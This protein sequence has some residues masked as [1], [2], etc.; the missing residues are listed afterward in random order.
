MPVDEAD[1]HALTNLGLISGLTTTILASGLALAFGEPVAE[2]FGWVQGAKWLWIIPLMALSV[3]TYQVLNALA[4]RQQ[5]FG[6]I[7]RRSL[8]QSLTGAAAQIVGGIMHSGFWG[9][10]LGQLVGNV[11][12]TLSLLW[13]S[14]LRTSDARAARR[15]PRLMA[16][17]K[18]YRKFPLA[19]APAA[20]LNALSSHAPLILII[21]W[22]GATAAGLLALTQRVLALPVL[23][24]SQAVGHVYLSKVSEARRLGSRD[25]SR[26]FWRTS[27]SLTLVA[28]PLATILLLSAP[29]LF[30]LVFGDEWA[31]SGQLAQLMAIAFAAQLIASPLSQTLI[32]L[33]RVWTQLLFDALR[34]AVTT[35]ALAVC[36]LTNQGL[37]IAVAAYSVTSA[38]TYVLI[39]ALS[40][41]AA[42]TASVTGSS[43][44][45]SRW[46]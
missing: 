21:T 16:V 30:S 23:I 39:W 35:G 8:A 32:A 25:V 3:S 6:A 20:L 27:M 5:R 2:T 37:Q 36:A 24:I 42:M 12:G 33:E 7:G 11:V 41:R 28:F 13:G 45:R 43:K 9:L 34:L 14:G 31:A 10:S 38:A 19:L 4:I 46:K 44:G 1:A 26:L 17:G 15:R 29:S 40:R 18:R 22:Y